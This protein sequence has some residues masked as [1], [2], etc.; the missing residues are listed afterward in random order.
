VFVFHMLVEEHQLHL[1]AVEVLRR[2]GK[3]HRALGLQ[4]GL[5]RDFGVGVGAH[6]SAS[7]N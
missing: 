7:T 1:D 4:H 2:L 6:L 5:A 3:C